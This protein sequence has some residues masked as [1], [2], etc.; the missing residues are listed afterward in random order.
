MVCPQDGDMVCLN[1]SKGSLDVLSDEFDPREAIKIDLSTNEYGV[2]R[3]L[4]SIF[5]KNVG[6]ASEGASIFS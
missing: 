4:F 3:E 6:N 1:A 2:G 5:R